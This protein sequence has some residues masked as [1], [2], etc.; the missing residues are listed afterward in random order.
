MY[1]ELTLAEIADCL[2]YSSAA[3]LSAQFKQVTGLT[4]SYF[5]A[6]GKQRRR[7]LDEI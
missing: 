7:P 1:G 3:Y 5:K 6:K 4:P 2:G